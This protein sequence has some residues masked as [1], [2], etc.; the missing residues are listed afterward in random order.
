MISGV[1][2]VGLHRSPE[3][4]LSRRV[5]SLCGQGSTK[6]SPMSG[7]ARV[8]LHRSPELHLRLGMPGLTGQHEAET[9]MSGRGPR[10]ELDRFA[11]R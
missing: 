5:A 2:P 10:D 9:S 7:A 1:V 8:G 11:E 3:L 6:I 4:H